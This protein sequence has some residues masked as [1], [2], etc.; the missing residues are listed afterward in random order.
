[1]KK[2]PQSASG[3]VSRREYARRRGVDEKAIRKAIEAGILKAALRDGLIDV[4]AADALLSAHKIGGQQVSSGLVKARTRKLA[5]GVALLRDEI[6][7]LQASTLPAAGVAAL[8]RDIAL[9]V[10]RIFWAMTNTAARL[11]GL[12]RSTAIAVLDDEVRARLQAI[13]DTRVQVPR[14]KSRKREDDRSALSEMSA[15]DLAAERATLQATR[16]EIERGLR[17]GELVDLATAQAAAVDRVLR[18]R[19]KVLA[20]PAKLGASMGETV[21]AAELAPVL[22]AE[23]GAALAELA[24]DAV[25]AAEIEAARHQAVDTL[26]GRMTFKL[27]HHE[28]TGP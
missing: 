28:R 27:H 25:S 7:D 14:S 13:A 17:V 10:S 3:H 15:V 22:E 18:M 5:A 21:D 9:H 20:L 23:L 8:T 16:M 4:A 6:V 12:E 24:C 11:A 1:M 2:G 26:P 19:T